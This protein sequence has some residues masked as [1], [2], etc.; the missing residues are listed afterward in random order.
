MASVSQ[1]VSVFMT[2]YVAEGMGVSTNSGQ[3]SARRIG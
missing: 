2:D 3:V 1:I